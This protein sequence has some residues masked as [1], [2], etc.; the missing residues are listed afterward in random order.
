MIFIIILSLIVSSTIAQMDRT[1][2]PALFCAACK[3]TVIELEKELRKS[4]KR[5]GIV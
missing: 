2:T 4:P 1:V 3:A 5:S